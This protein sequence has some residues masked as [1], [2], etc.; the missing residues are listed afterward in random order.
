MKTEYISGQPFFRNAL[1]SHDRYKDVIAVIMM[2]IRL[3][4]N[5]LF[6]GRTDRS[7]TAI[8]VFRNALRWKTQWL[9][10]LMGKTI[11]KK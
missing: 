8:R 9:Y 4:S 6:C 5:V 2:I 7:V 1:M 11:T 3:K 10:L